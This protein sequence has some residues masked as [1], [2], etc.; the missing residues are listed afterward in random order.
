MDNFWFIMWMLDE[1]EKCDKGKNTSSYVSHAPS[2]P[3]KA[4]DW[5][6]QHQMILGILI[7]SMS[8]IIPFVIYKLFMI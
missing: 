7:G 3:N 6:E 5:F 2:K 4:D 8:W 1:D